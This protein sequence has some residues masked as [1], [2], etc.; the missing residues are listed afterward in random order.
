MSAEGRNNHHIGG[1]FLARL[2]KRVHP[3]RPLGKQR[4]HPND[5]V[6]GQH[7]RWPQP[8]LNIPAYN[9]LIWAAFKPEWWLS[10]KII[11]VNPDGSFDRFITQPFGELAENQFSLMQY[12]FTLFAGLAMQKYMSTLIADQTPFDRFQAGD[13]TA[14]NA[15]EQRG[16]RVYLNSAANGGGNCKPCHSVPETTRASVR[17]ARGVSSADVSPPP[18]IR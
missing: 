4:V 9:V 7:S 5:S 17:R 13:T 10:A 1:K 6:L 2:S 16:L 14:L 15:Q 8:G 3:L 11:Q 18:P 12:N